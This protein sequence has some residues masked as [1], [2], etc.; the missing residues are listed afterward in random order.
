MFANFIYFIIVLVIYTTYQPSADRIASVSD[1]IIRFGLILAAFAVIA[2]IVFKRITAGISKK[3]DA[4]TDMIFHQAMNRLSIMAIMA[5]F[6]DIYILNL[7]S[8]FAGVQLFGRLP[9]LAALMF[10]AL[11]VFKLVIIWFYA[12]PV[13]RKLYPGRISRRRYIESQLTF[14][15]PVLMPWFVLSFATDLMGNLPFADI[16]RVFSTSYGEFG[17]ILVFLIIFVITGP[18]LIQKVWRCK[19]LEAGPQRLRIERLCRQ[20]KLSYA[21][22]LKWPIMGGNTLTAAVMGVIGRFRYILISPALLYFLEPEEMD[23]V[24]A[25]ETG[26]VKKYHLQLYLLF[27]AGYVLVYFA[28]FELILCFVVLSEP[29]F[30]LI[31]WSGM[32]AGNVSAAVMGGVLVTFL[33]VYFRY[34]FGF[35]MRNCERQADMYVYELLDDAR[36]LISAF[37]KI[38]AAG[39]QSPDRPN[40]HHFSIQQRIDYLHKCETDRSWI[41]H[42]NDKVRKIVLGYLGV[43]VLLGGVGYQFNYGDMGQSLR[44]YCLQRTYTYAL[45]ALQKH[46]NRFSLLGDV[47]YSLKDYQKAIDAYERA[48]VENPNDA[49]LLNNLAWLY[50]TCEDEAFLNY[51]QALFLAQKAAA[52]EPL[53]H[54]LDTLAESLFVNG[55]YEE[56]VKTERQAVRAAEDNRLY[57]QNQLERFMAAQQQKQMMP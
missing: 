49:E 1:T 4:A 29:V 7:P 34:F 51:P 39:G 25:H 20:A 37:Q 22:I 54:I 56:A 5:F 17:Y 55:R 32:D 14:A 24:I 6:I 15:L 30:K 18:F 13:H 19:P 11:F 52:L 35:V 36:P 31:E 46:P 21:E 12:Y 40:W 9:T 2:R 53:A 57:Y 8:L 50:A 48:I 28:F 33:I 45:D 27:F 16:R 44:Q 10:V 42:H 3:G 26:H 38:A 23:A 41:K 43:L 47:Y